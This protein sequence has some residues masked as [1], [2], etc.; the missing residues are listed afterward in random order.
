MKTQIPL[1]LLIA[2]LSLSTAKHTERAAPGTPITHQLHPKPQ[3]RKLVFSPYVNVNEDLSA[4]ELD[5]EDEEPEAQ[6]YNPFMGPFQNAPVPAFGMGGMMPP[7]LGLTSMPY[8]YMYGSPALHPLNPINPIN[9]LGQS[10]S[11]GNGLPQQQNGGLGFGF[12]TGLSNGLG[13]GL[14]GGVSGGYV[15]RQLGN[16]SP[17]AS[18]PINVGLYCHDRKKQTIEI[19]K[20]IMKKQ[21]DIIFHELMNYLLKTKTLVSSSEVQLTKD[22]RTKIYNVMSQF[23]NVNVGNI[24]FNATNDVEGGVEE[25]LVGQDDRNDADGLISQ[26]IRNSSDNSIGGLASQ[27]FGSLGEEQPGIEIT[28]QSESMTDAG[29]KIEDEFKKND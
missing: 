16:W 13:N 27:S 28:I 18:S 14:P 2:A 15:G 17:F 21:N 26:S 25:S 5:K 8:N 20:A 10:Q 29:P 22:L 4:R 6:E 12:D 9:P 7:S 19:A 1:L 3:P 23:G 11:M 24:S